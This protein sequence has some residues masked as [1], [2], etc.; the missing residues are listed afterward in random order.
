MKKTIYII[1]LI[2][3][4]SL[5][6]FQSF[7]KKTT[8]KKVSNNIEVAESTEAEAQYYSQ[9]ELMRDFDSETD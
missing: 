6:S 1:V 8:T 3:C 2:A 5:I 9:S 7:S 4:V